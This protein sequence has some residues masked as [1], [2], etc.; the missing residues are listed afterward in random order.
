ML[1]NFLCIIFLVL[2]TNS[3]SAKI[4]HS[5]DGKF[6]YTSKTIQTNASTTLSASST[7]RVYLIFNPAINFH[8]SESFYVFTDT[9]FGSEIDSSSTLTGFSFGG[10]YFFLQPGSKIVTTQ[11]NLEYSR[12]PNWAPFVTVSYRQYTVS[13]SSLSF[14]FSGLRMETGSKISEIKNL[15]LTVGLSYESM[16]SGTDRTLSGLGLFSALSYLF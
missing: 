5:F 7:Q 10:G 16:S 13:S 9:L 6:E 14:K 12:I 8:L 11:K 15:P 4:Y 1:K 2:L 3:A